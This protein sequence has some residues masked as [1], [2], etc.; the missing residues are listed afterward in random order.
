MNDL[1]IFIWPW[2]VPADPLPVLQGL[3]DKGITVV[4]TAQRLMDYDPATDS[5]K[6]LTPFLQ[7][8]KSI[9]LKTKVGIW[10]DTKWVDWIPNDLR[11]V[12][13]NAKAGTIIS[14]HLNIFHPHAIDLLEWFGTEI[15]TK[16]KG[17]VDIYALATNISME[18]DLHNYATIKADDPDLKR[19]IRAMVDEAIDDFAK[20]VVA[21]DSTPL[22]GP[23]VGSMVHAHEGRLSWPLGPKYTALFTGD[24]QIPDAWAVDAGFTDHF[25]LCAF[26]ADVMLGSGA[27]YTQSEIMWDGNELDEAAIEQSAWILADRGVTFNIISLNSLEAVEKYPALVAKLAEIAQRHNPVEPVGATVIGTY[28]DIIGK[29]RDAG[30]GVR[31]PVPVIIIDE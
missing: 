15:A 6:D 26:A 10:A 27:S 1:A 13:G 19:K 7:A 18:V 21:V 12:D 22:V 25:E 24:A 3:K 9:G 2:Y 17:L 8:A 16:Y 11:I 28:S 14:G 30:G 29:W 5:W 20:A 23:Q 31:K 4:A